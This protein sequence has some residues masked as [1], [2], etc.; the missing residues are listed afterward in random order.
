MDTALT[1]RS[2]L[3]GSAA[4]ALTTNFRPL[5]ATTMAPLTIVINQSPWF[6]SFRKTVELYEH[7]TGSK[8]ELDVNPFR[9][10]PGKAAQFG[11]GRHGR[12]RQR[13]RKE[14]SP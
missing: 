7:E 8:V 1:R 4:L 11:A 2:L 12:S 6:D 5:H 9:R 13:R 3:A 10:L 14:A